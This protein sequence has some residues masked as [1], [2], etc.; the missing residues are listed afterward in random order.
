MP[1]PIQIQTFICILIL[2]F[3]C[4]YYS[5]VFRH[6]SKHHASERNRDKETK[7]GQIFSPLITPIIPSKTGKTMNS[8]KKKKLLYIKR[9]FK[10]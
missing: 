5:E 3:P 10:S 4:R 2:N 8:A 1:G 6:C 7:M 9:I